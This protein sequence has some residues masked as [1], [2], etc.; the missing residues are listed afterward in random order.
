M[1]KQLIYSFIFITLIIFLQTSRANT[2]NQLENTDS[3][4]TFPKEGRVCHTEGAYCI[5]YC[6]PPEG[7]GCSMMVCKDKKWSYVEE[8]YGN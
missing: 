6:D 4:T 3:C 5:I 2:T 1:I 7:F 8:I